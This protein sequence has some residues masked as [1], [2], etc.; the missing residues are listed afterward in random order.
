MKCLAQA[1]PTPRHTLAVQSAQ[2]AAYDQVEPID[3]FRPAGADPKGPAPTEVRKDAAAEPMFTPIVQPGSKI[4]AERLAF[5]YLWALDFRCR[6]ME[7]VLV[8]SEKSASDP[9]PP[10]GEGTGAGV[11]VSRPAIFKMAGSAQPPGRLLGR[12]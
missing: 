3:E 5:W 1:L 6:G 7:F 12:M 11:I 4:N 9:A 2:P 8:Q 10:R